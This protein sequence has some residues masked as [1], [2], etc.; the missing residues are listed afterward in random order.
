MPGYFTKYHQLFPKGKI[1]TVLFL[2]ISFSAIAQR[3]H[4]PDSVNVPLSWANDSATVSDSIPALPLDEDSAYVKYGQDSTK[5]FSNKASFSQEI[6]RVRHLPDSVI[7]KIKQDKEF[8]YANTVFAKNKKNMDSQKSGGHVP[9]SERT[10]FQTL[11][12]LIIIG[13]FAAFIM[14]FLANSNVSLFR[15][16]PKSISATPVDEVETDDIFVINYPKEIEKAISRSNYRFAVRLMFLKLLK[17]LS[18]KNIIQY[19][20]DKTNL[21][22]LLQLHPTN[23]YQEFFRITRNY[24]YSWY[25]KFEISPEKFSLIKNEFEKLEQRLG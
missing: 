25:G 8:W 11:L 14:I 15:R 22:Y 20:Q 13:C 1:L 21:D 6:I 18:D 10:W 4:P 24:E 17:Q 9:L 5:Y 3:H 16:K 7:N 19:K 2:L 12:W 23:Y